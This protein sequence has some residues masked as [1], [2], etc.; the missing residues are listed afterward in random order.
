MGK[1]PPLVIA[2]AGQWS[3]VFG[4]SSSSAMTETKDG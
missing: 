1:L 3:A 2:N 4:M